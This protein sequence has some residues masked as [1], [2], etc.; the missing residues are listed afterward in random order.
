VRYALWR[1]GTPELRHMLDRAQ[2]ATNGCVCKLRVLQWNRFCN[3]YTVLFNLAA[4]LLPRWLFRQVNELLRAK[5]DY[6]R[7]SRSSHCP[8]R[9]QARAPGVPIARIIAGSNGSCAECRTQRHGRELGSLHISHGAGSGCSCS[10]SS[11]GSQYVSSRSYSKCCTHPSQL[12]NSDAAEHLAICTSF[13]VIPRT[14]V[15]SG[16]YG[17]G[18]IGYDQLTN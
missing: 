3:C 14:S 8:D 5:C 10:I 15:Q 9:L 18:Q 4:C 13:A 7:W 11:S 17:G 12:S 1:P 6:R 2:N 16:S